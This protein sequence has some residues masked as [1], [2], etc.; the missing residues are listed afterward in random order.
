[1][2]NTTLLKAEVER[3]QARCDETLP[4]YVMKSCSNVMGA[5][6]MSKQKERKV[7]RWIVTCPNPDGYNITPMELDFLSNQQRSF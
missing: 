6:E 1:M 5:E 3:L 2:E 7:R 4:D